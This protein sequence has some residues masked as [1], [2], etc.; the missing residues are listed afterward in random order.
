M[1]TTR[2]DAPNMM[3]PVP[4]SGTVEDGKL[5]FDMP[6]KAVAVVEVE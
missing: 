1:R 2:F 5:A 6:A 4:F 3:H